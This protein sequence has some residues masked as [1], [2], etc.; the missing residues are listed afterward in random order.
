[1]YTL[2][3]YPLLNHC[4]LLSNMQIVKLSG[5]CDCHVILTSL[6]ATVSIV[7]SMLSVGAESRGVVSERVLGRLRTELLSV[8]LK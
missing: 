7:V 8:L 5:T 3:I 4:T 2:E 1:M 6:V